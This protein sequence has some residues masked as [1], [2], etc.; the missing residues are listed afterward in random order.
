MHCGGVTWDTKGVCNSGPARQQPTCDENRHPVPAGSSLAPP[1]LWQCPH[2]A[3]HPLLPGSLL[4]SDQSSL[5]SSWPQARLSVRWQGLLSHLQG[6]PVLCPPASMLPSPSHP[7]V[8]QQ[9]AL[10]LRLSQPFSPD[11]TPHNKHKPPDGVPEFELEMNFLPCSL[12]CSLLPC[13]SCPSQNFSPS[14]HKQPIN[15]R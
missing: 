4:L 11:P 9:L 5:L 3:A 13:I 8:L 6:N 10:C 2:H 7:F 15:K 12:L 1:K 14:W